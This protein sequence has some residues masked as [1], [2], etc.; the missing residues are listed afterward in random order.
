MYK[1][2]VVKG[3]CIGIPDEKTDSI[4]PYEV[5]LADN[6]W[7]A[8]APIYLDEDDTFMTDLDRSVVCCN[9]SNKNSLEE[10]GFLLLEEE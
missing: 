8:M 1:M 9:D 5:V 6:E 2:L 7:F 4:T 3:D 10:M